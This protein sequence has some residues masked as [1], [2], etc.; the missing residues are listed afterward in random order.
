MILSFSGISRNTTISYRFVMFLYQFRTNLVLIW[1][2]RTD[3]PPPP[4]QH[5]SYRSMETQYRDEGAF[6]RVRNPHT[7]QSYLSSPTSI[8]HASTP[9]PPRSWWAPQTSIRYIRDAPRATP[10]SGGHWLAASRWLCALVGY[11]TPRVITGGGRLIIAITVTP[12][13]NLITWKPEFNTPIR[14][15]KLKEPEVWCDR[16]SKREKKDEPSL[17][18]R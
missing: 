8:P 3:A 6:F 18:L 11:P 5:T 17:R 12:S 14:G 16:H 2:P 4:D 10:G 13:H 1:T 7:N 15:L 9:M